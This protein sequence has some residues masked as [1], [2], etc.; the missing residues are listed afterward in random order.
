MFDLKFF[1]CGAAFCPSLGNTNAWFA[2][3]STLYLLDCGESTFEKAVRLVHP[4]QYEKIYVLLTHMHADHCGSLASL[5]S[6]MFFKFDKRV[7]I[8]HP[9][10]NIVAMLAL[11]GIGRDNYEYFPELPAWESIRCSFL[12]VKHADDMATFGC[13]LSDEDETIYYSGDASELLDEVREAFLAGKISRIYHDTASHPSTFHCWYQLLVDAIPTELRQ[14][15]C[16]MH[17][18]GDYS[19]LLLNL[20]FSVAQVNE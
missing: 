20:G 11:Q 15:V 4:E 13:L 8:V 10:E 16:C 3:G 18:D 14:N 9:S 2:K 1:G 5:C 19:A 12:P 6:Y 7:R 17:L